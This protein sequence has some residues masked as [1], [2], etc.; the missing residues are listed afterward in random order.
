MFV[1]SKNL[2]IKKKGKTVFPF[3]PFVSVGFTTYFLP[4]AASTLSFDNFLVQKNQS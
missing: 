4:S 2:F 1:L 3:L